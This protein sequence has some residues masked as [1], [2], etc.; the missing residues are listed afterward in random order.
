MPHNGRVNAACVFA[1]AP[2]RTPLPSATPGI[3]G[4]RCPAGALPP[5]DEDRDEDREDERLDGRNEAQGGGGAGVT[6]RGNNRMYSAS[7]AG[8]P[9][10]PL[11]RGSGAV[12]LGTCG[13][14]RMAGEPFA[15]DKCG[16][17]GSW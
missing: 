6:E 13:L 3:E 2:L 5:G 15:A 10:S 8:E 1:T 14:S 7:D 12:M 9:S 11:S 4:R 17:S 16:S